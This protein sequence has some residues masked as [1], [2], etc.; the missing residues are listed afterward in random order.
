MNLLTPAYL[1]FLSLLIPVILLYFIKPKR[2]RVFVPSFHIWERMSRAQQANDL[3]KKIKRLISLI[4]HCLLVLLLTLALAR[5]FFSDRLVPQ[6]IVVILD[7]S[8]SMLALA[9]DDNGQLDE[10]RRRFDNAR[11][12][13][14]QLA[15]DLSPEDRMMLIEAASQPRV[16]MPL[17][18]DRGR[19]QSVLDTLSARP[20]QTN[21]REAMSLAQAVARQLSAK[22]EKVREERKN[23]WDGGLF[24]ANT[25]ESETVIFV[26]SDGTDS[27]L[28]G[29]NSTSKELKLPRRTKLFYVPFGT[30]NNPNA[31]LTA[32]AVRELLNSPGDH[33]VLATAHNYSNTALTVRP[34]LFLASGTEEDILDSLPQM[35]IPPNK[36]VPLPINETNIRRSGILKLRLTVTEVAGKPLDQSSWRDLLAVDD[37]AYAVVPEQRFKKVLLVS[38]KRNLFLEAAL[39]EDLSI[40]ADRL[41]APGYQALSKKEKASYD[42]I[43][44]DQ[45]LPDEL[46]PT[47]LMFFA[48]RGKIS[49]LEGEGIISVPM[50]K[51]YQ[52]DHPVM[53]YVQMETVN[54]LR[55]QKLI[56]TADRRW[57]T[58]VSSFRG[59][60]IVAGNFP[61]RRMLYVAFHAVDTDMV[62]RKS[63]P[64]LISNSIE[65]LSARRRQPLNV[66]SFQTGKAAS[67]ELSGVTERRLAVWTPVRGSK[68]IP[69]PI[70]NG[71]ATFTRTEAIGVYHAAPI[72]AGDVELL[73]QPKAPKGSRRFTVNLLSQEEGQIQLQSS[74]GVGEEVVKKYEAGFELEIR[75][76]LIWAILILL[77]LESI[78]FHFLT[79]F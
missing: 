27:K 18:G 47:E 15:S 70:H 25:E 9:P 28:V 41:L 14:K 11:D 75:P 36:S 32:F 4:L 20:A 60:L 13:A 2:K 61:H 50:V 76:S 55:A 17:S 33:E 23:S 12:F 26:L 52:K 67:L 53:R 58:L 51:D 54:F 79:V 29:I 22:A 1:G 37:V 6:R 46:P 7:A 72:S 63:W 69:V 45:F 59:P 8:T 10:R 49:P 48:T 24:Q 66:P 78:L 65:W 43:I 56:P 40:N 16:V 5:P 57:R 44:F 42:V 73:K 64:I 77:L 31:G 39:A 74:L 21:L 38:A 68:A 34:E 35:V 71:R 19:I 62:L 3:L 30:P